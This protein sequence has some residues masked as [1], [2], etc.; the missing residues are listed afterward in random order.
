MEQ[1]S[2]L[3][4]EIY[5]SSYDSA[6]NVMNGKK[7]VTLIDARMPKLFEADEEA[8]A[9]RLVTR[10]LFGKQY[11]HA[12]PMEAGNYAFGGSFV[13]TS[14]S[15]LRDHFDYP[16]PL[17]DR[18]MNLEKKVSVIRLFDYLKDPAKYTEGTSYHRID[19]I[20]TV[21]QLKKVLGDPDYSENDGQDKVN[22]EWERN[23]ITGE[24]FTVYDW[25]EYR[26]ISQTE[27]ITWHIGAKNTAIALQAREEILKALTESK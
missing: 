25:K 16:I 3:P 4:L 20:A 12:E 18:N 17:H 26:S 21:E 13:F 24:C 6:M 9:I 2:G 5:R 8:P 1:A 10:N 22:Y 14:D 15:R 23:V 11:T 27:V 7:S 19:I